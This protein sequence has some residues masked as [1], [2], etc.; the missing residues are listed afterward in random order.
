MLATAGHLLG[1]PRASFPTDN[2]LWSGHFQIG[3]TQLA[4]NSLSPTEQC[5]GFGDCHI[6]VQASGNIHDRILLI[7]VVVW[8]GDQGRFGDEL[9]LRVAFPSWMVRCQPKL[10][11][12]STA[13][14]VDLAI[15]LAPS[16]SSL[17]KPMTRFGRG[18]VSSSGPSRPVPAWPRLF[19]PQPQTVPFSST[20]NEW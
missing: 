6:A 17:L 16:S 15:R 2:H 20:A 12:V 7:L 13:T 18:T 1:R 9:F 5:A 11:A 14:G 19:N 3:N 8:E 4:L 10:R